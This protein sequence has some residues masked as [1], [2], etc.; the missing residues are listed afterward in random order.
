MSDPKFNAGV[1]DIRTPEQMLVIVKAKLDMFEVIQSVGYVQTKFDEQK[2]GVY[3][4]EVEEGIAD[5]EV[6][7]GMG[8]EKSSFDVTL[9]L[10]SDY[11]RVIRLD[12]PDKTY[13]YSAICQVD[14]DNLVWDVTASAPEQ[15]IQEY[16]DLI[17]KLRQFGSGKFKA[18]GETKYLLNG[19]KG[20]E[21]P[22][23]DRSML[24]KK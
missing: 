10:D 1:V 6:Q 4:S 8:A 5:A 12:L 14:F 22:E 7:L 3:D 11:Y 19:G 13:K 20:Q 18:L 24:L 17:D 15:T 21:N 16:E 23:F 2:F 9:N